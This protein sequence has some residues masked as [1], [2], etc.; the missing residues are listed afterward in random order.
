MA[1]YV[2]DM[3]API[4]CMIMCHMV[5]DRRA[6]LFAMAAEIGVAGK[7]VQQALTPEEHFLICLSKRARAVMLGAVETD[8][9]E[10]ALKCR[11]RRQDF[12]RRYF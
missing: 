1:I 5:A 9:R 3:R 6:E 2:D 7:W 11:D 8:Q 12:V 10:L 4:G